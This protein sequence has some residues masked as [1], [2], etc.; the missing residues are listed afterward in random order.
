MLR[1]LIVE[2]DPMVAQINQEFCER[3]DHLQVVAHMTSVVQA[4]EFLD[5]NTCD[6]ILLDVYLPG[7]SGLELLV[8]LRQKGSFIPTVLITASDEFDT[9]EKAYAYGVIDYLI[10]PFSFDRF[11][12]AM[13]KVIQFYDASQKR[14]RTDQSLLD[15]LFQSQS[16]STQTRQLNNHQQIALDEYQLVELPKGLSKL[17]L[18]KVYQAVVQAEEW[19]STEDIADKID[20]SRIS[21]KKY[22]QFMVDINFLIER[23][24][25]RRVGR[26]VTLYKIKQDDHRE[27]IMEQLIN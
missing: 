13:E 4:E 15:H 27:N 18:R 14:G 5:N 1:V 25:Y 24:D 7:K 3:I 2:D 10:K 12:V 26:P 8:D 20:I 23:M 19:F 11:K 21:T 16:E 17:T 22:I 6:L 9:L